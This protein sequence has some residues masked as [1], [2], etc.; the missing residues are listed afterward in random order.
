MRERPCHCVRF[1]MHFAS[2]CE[3]SWCGEWILVAKLSYHLYTEG[4]YAV[5]L[6]GVPFEGAFEIAAPS[7]VLRGHLA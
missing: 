6:Y 7:T 3:T 5:E 1:R 4:N 2:D